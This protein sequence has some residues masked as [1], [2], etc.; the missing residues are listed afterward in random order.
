MVVSILFLEGPSATT[1]RTCW[2]PGIP[3]GATS[4]LSA[5][6]RFDTIPQDSHSSPTH[7]SR[8]AFVWGQQT[9]NAT[10]GLS[11]GHR[12]AASHT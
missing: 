5:G 11:R 9:A 1:M 8:N 12:L 7:L 2:P 4:L 3:R 6:A 10:P